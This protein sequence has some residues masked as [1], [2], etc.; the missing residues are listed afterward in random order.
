VC[1]CVCCMWIIS[2]KQNLSSVTS[3]IDKMLVVYIRSNNS[4]RMDTNK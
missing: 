2:M 4:K 3:D 1:V